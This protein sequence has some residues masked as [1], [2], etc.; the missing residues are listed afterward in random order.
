MPEQLNKRV[1]E[2]QA[3]KYKN[4][5]IRKKLPGWEIFVESPASNNEITFLFGEDIS[6]ERNNV[7]GDSSSI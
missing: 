7:A 1:I 2:D 6:E 4:D 3:K 5:V